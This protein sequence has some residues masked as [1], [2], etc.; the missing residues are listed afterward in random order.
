MTVGI[1]LEWHHF[2]RFVEIYCL[3][4][5][6]KS[7]LNQVYCGRILPGIVFI[8]FWNSKIWK[9]RNTRNRSAALV[10]IVSLQ[11]SNPVSWYKHQGPQDFKT[12]IHTPGS[13][14]LW[15][16]SQSS[17]DWLALSLDCPECH[18]GSQMIVSDGPGIYWPTSV[19]L[20]DK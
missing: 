17:R 11:S 16:S 15:Y 13:P 1:A 4:K 19:E 18:L 20:L 8:R 5:T 12:R 6:K 9:L 10:Q 3:A 7:S 2:Q 14:S